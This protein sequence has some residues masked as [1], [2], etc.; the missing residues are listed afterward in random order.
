MDWVAAL[1]VDQACV[2]ARRSGRS[3]HV[4]MVRY[5]EPVDDR[6]VQ[7]ALDVGS[8]PVIVGKTREYQAAL[9]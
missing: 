5:Y 6:P 8:D 4:W 9:L 7:R 3:S 2:T 1:L